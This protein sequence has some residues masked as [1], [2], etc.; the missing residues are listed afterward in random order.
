MIRLII[1]L[2]YNKGNL[3]VCSCEVEDEEGTIM[4]G[5]LDFV[6]L[7]T[8]VCFV[9]SSA[10]KGF[11]ALLIKH[12]APFFLP[13]SVFMQIQLDCLGFPWE[14]QRLRFGSLAV[15]GFGFHRS[16][17]LSSRCSDAD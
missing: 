8:H 4:L 6:E 5:D 1:S 7:P 3:T 14:L 10:E 16:L 9:L 15:W 13:E 12:A 11:D 17:A 2:M